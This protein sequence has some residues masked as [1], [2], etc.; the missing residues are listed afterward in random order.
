MPGMGELRP[1]YIFLI[2]SQQRRK[3]KGRIQKE[4]Y[5]RKT[6][7]ALGSLEQV[8]EIEVHLGT[9]IPDTVPGRNSVAVKKE[10]QAGLVLQRWHLLILFA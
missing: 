6:L 2:N 1:I 5:C 4:C 9:K 3:E 7:C 8:P 10:T